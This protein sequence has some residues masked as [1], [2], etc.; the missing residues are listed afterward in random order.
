M[1]DGRPVFREDQPMFEDKRSYKQYQGD[2]V[3]HASTANSPRRV[4]TAIMHF[5]LLTGLVLLFGSVHPILSLHVRPRQTLPLSNTTSLLDVIQVAPPVRFYSKNGDEESPSCQSLLVSYSFGNSYGQPFVGPYTPPACDF[6]RVTWNL[7]VTSSG[8]QFD[9]LGTVSLG[10]IEV[11]RTSTAEPTAN[12]IIW[13]YIKDV[14]PFLSLFKQP[15]TLIFDLGNIINDIYTGPFNVTLTASYYTV[16]DTDT[17][18]AADS[19]LPISK[20]LQNASS[21]FNVPPDNATNLITI[22]QNVEKAIVTVAAT[23]QSSEEFWWSNVLE[24]DVNDFPSA[25]TLPGLSPFREVQLLI[26]GNLAGVVWP[27]PVIFTG[28]VVPGFWRPIV[29]IDAYDLREDEIDISPWLPLLSDNQ[30]HNFTLVVTGLVP[31]STNTTSTLSERV[32]TYWVVDAKIFL[33]LSPTSEPTTGTPPTI[34]TPVPS[35]LTS[36][37]LTPTSSNDSTLTYSV[38]VSRSLSITSTLHLPTGP[39]NATWSQSLT[40]SSSGTLSSFGNAQLSTLLVTGRDASSSGYER[41]INYPLNVSSLYIPRAD[42]F[43]L[44]AS[45]TRGK[46]VRTFGPS[47]FPKGLESF[48][49]AGQYGGGRGKGAWLDTT[50]EGEARYESNTTSNVATSYGDTRQVLK[51]SEVEGE[52]DAGRELYFR[53][54]E[55]RNGTIVADEVRDVQSGGDGGR[56]GGGGGQHVQFAVRLPGLRGSGMSVRGPPGA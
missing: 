46:D 45:L 19:I 9:R 35:I 6:N 23:G 25:G 4:S 39:R 24:Q 32:N 40:H 37:T 17:L 8:R 53:D 5:C 29:G 30:A 13:T 2:H 28:G 47:V 11:F 15:Q 22:P 38:S 31:D 52:E 10:E 36:S 27:F 1:H 12:G 50:Q 42:G 7:T 20:R 18:P 3:Q 49:G 26:D 51:F 34:S 16:D 56:R 41:F 44:S 21:V 43:G 48:S 14:S 54:V 55:G 33:W